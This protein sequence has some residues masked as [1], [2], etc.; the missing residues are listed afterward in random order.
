MNGI[1]KITARIESDGKAEAEAILREAREKAG[2]IKANYEAQVRANAQQDAEKSKSAAALRA[3]RLEGAAEMDAKKLRLAAKQECLDEAF[4][5]AEKKLT[6]LGDEEYS[7]LLAQIAAKASR[8]GREEVILSE[9]DRARVGDLAVAKA[10]AKLAEAAAPPA[11]EKLKKGSKA[12][13]V[14]SV[15]L[16]VGSAVTQGAALLTLS[17]ETRNIDGGLIL[18]DGN[19]EINC[20][21]DTLLRVLR[22]S[23]ASEVAA[24]LF[25]A[26]TR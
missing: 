13:Q 24:L 9:K 16:T 26:K 2:E 22:E 5:L 10:N 6:E 17:K 1:G 18:R 20:A 15:M 12:K 7:D 25:P 14:L 11:A 8:T 19:V 4:A 23:M 21:F 3:Q